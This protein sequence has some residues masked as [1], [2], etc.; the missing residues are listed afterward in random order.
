MQ[1]YIGM[2]LFVSVVDIDSSKWSTV[3]R[4]QDEAS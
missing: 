3:R 1:I 2:D 4:W